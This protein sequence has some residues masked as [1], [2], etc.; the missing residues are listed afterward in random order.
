MRELGDLRGVNAD[1]AD[2]SRDILAS[3]SWDVTCSAINVN[4][5]LIVCACA[6]REDLVTFIGDGVVII[7]IKNLDKTLNETKHRVEKE[8]N[9]YQIHFPDLPKN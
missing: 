7:N 2:H 1:G 6:I 4:E 8:E 5:E 9:P 3:V